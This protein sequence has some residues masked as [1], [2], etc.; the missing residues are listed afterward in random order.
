MVGG[1]LQEGRDDECQGTAAHGAHQG[2]DQVQAGD[3]DGQDAC[4]RE[5]TPVDDCPELRETASLFSKFSKCS[6]HSMESS[7]EAETSSSPISH[8]TD[9]K[10]DARRC[11]M[12]RVSQQDGRTG[13]GNQSSQL[14]LPQSLTSTFLRKRSQI[15][16]QGHPVLPK[17]SKWRA[18]EEVNLF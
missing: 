5:D 12:T 7:K 11:G 3:E 8:S 1:D 17:E 15:T 18:G 16:F 9:E 2:D 10:T 4:G 14:R 6:S 13:T